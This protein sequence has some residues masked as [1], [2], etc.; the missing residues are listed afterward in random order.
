MKLEKFL[1]L[2]LTL[3]TI[4]FA[5]SDKI[6]LRL[7]HNLNP[8]SA[9][10]SQ[11]YRTTSVDT[12]RLLAVMVDFAVDQDAATYG[13]GKFGS[14]YS[15]DYGKSII[16][17]LPHDRNYFKSHLEFLKNYYQKISDGKIIIQYEVL[18]RIVSL[19]NVMSYYSPPPKSNDLSRLGILFEDV[20]RKVDS[21]YPDQD[22]TKYDVFTIFHAGVGRDIV[23]PETFGL[24]K[25]IPSVYLSPT[26][27][28]NFFGANYQGVKIGNPPKYVLNSMI[29]PETESREIQTLTGKA[30]LELS[31]NGLLAASFGSFLG[32]PDLFD[33]KTG[34]TAIGRFGLMDG[35]AMF[36]YA[37]LFLPEPSAWEKYF[38]GLVEPIEI[39]KDTLN[40]EVFARLASINNSKTVYKI[41]INSREYYLIEN[42][43]KD[44]LNDGIKIKSQI[45]VNL[46]EYNFFKDFRNFSSYYVDT[47]DGVVIDVD[48]FDWAT[49][50]NGILIW[51]IDEKIIAENFADNS[52]NANP[53]LRGIKL[54]EADGIQDIGNE[55]TTIFGDVIVG[56]GDSVDFWFKNNPSKFYKNEFS[57]ETKPRTLS[58]NGTPSYIKIYNFSEVN[59]QM[60]F[61]VSFGNEKIK[62]IVNE[63]IAQSL[64]TEFIHRNEIDTNKIF[65]KSDNE[66]FS[67]DL[68]TKSKQIFSNSVQTNI[69]FINFLNGINIYS[70][71]ESN[72]S[73]ELLLSLVYI[74]SDTIWVEQFKLPF[75][76]NVKNLI[77]YP[78]SQLLSN[79]V[80]EI[81]RE[82]GEQY[83]FKSPQNTFA[84]TGLIV[85]DKAIKSAYNGYRT[86][87]LTSKY[88][89]FGNTKVEHSLNDPVE[90]VLSWDNS[91]AQTPAD[92]EI[93]VIFDKS[94]F[95]ETLNEK[96][97]I[98]RF[99]IDL[100]DSSFTIA[101]GNLKPD[102]TNYIFVNTKDK[103]LAFNKSGAMA[104]NFPIY[105]PF[106]TKFIGNLNLIDYNNDGV[107][108]ILVSTEDG[109]L[110]CYDGKKPS[111][112]LMD[113]LITY[114]IGYPSSGSSLIYN[115]NK[116][117]YLTG[118]DSGFVQLVQIADEPKII[119]WTL[120]SN[121]LYN[122][123]VSEIPAGAFYRDEFLPKSKVY[124]WPNPVYD[125]ETNFRVYV[126]EDAK[127]KIKIYDL[128]GEF[129]DEINSY[130]L[131]GIE[132]DIKWN[133]ANIQSGIYFAR[134][135]AKSQSKSDYKIIKVAVV[136]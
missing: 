14:H 62:P 77:T 2:F 73:N 57:D 50:G 40:L 74:S 75:T 99:K 64:R 25:D 85:T 5:Q 11:I 10:E 120:N 107:N 88:V 93:A 128:N 17:P 3:S 76:N 31:I 34:K 118:N 89:Y 22:F 4:L 29:L 126:S 129:V 69:L 12:F 104:E 6:E 20:W 80:I 39:S 68:L 108:D 78:V 70:F 103:I 117:F 28:K 9:S 114:S 106:G 38:L 79:F 90:M 112:N 97:K 46:V 26:T 81:L 87:T 19:P 122:H 56:E 72:S 13:N 32:L 98:A 35:Q 92:K 7:P 91:L 101:A 115:Y 41:P 100:T 1:I 58:N 61:S 24:E 96:G 125:N 134:I 86:I 110:I 83:L 113:A 49:P 67:Y 109:R 135:D 51:H 123:N 95:V 45:G 42:R 66:F 37:G 121:N 33:T 21:L 133:V 63:R 47:V 65:I 53:K 82:N 52:I 18:D 116:T 105:P 54:I 102:E 23:I 111:Q 94:G 136:K 124:N 71:V 30:L 16:D 60:T 84:P 27:L 8:F 48:E 36:A 131:A 127:I 43:Q 130:A 119:K 59:N 132:T 44:V 15:K 55:F